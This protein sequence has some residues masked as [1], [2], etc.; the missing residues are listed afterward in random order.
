M[1]TQ[2]EPHSTAPK[3]CCGDTWDDGDPLLSAPLSLPLAKPHTHPLH[4]PRPLHAT[5]CH[6]ARWWGIPRME[7]R[8]AKLPEAGV[9]PAAFR[10]PLVHC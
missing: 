2:N 7:A 10:T 4:P 5:L 6:R 3:N 8:A 9:P 1:G